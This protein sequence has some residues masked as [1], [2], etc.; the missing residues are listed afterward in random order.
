[1]EIG[2]TNEKQL[3][4]LKKSLRVGDLSSGEESDVELSDQ[5]SRTGSELECDDTGGAV[6]SDDYGHDS[7]V[8]PVSYN[9]D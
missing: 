5:L 9:S 6:S 2:S 4:S 8:K 3:T 1:M 7:R